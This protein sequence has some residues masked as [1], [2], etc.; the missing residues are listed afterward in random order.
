MYAHI[1]ATRKMPDLK[2]CRGHRNPR[3]P[4]QTAQEEKFLLF[5]LAIAVLLKSFHTNS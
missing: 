5:A 2:K 3:Q 1:K 4:A